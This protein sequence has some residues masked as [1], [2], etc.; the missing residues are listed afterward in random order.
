MEVG[1]TL[2]PCMMLKL[3]LSEKLQGRYLLK[4]L[5]R[6][7]VYLKSYSRMRVDLAVQ[8]SIINYT[9]LINSDV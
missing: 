2:G 8:V 1:H 7:H 6:E 9:V 4:K 5:S 3:A